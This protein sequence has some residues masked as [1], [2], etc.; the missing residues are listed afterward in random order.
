MCA[1]VRACV[2]ACVC[3]ACVCEGSTQGKYVNSV[4]RRMLRERTTYRK[5]LTGSG[6]LKIR[7]FNKLVVSNR[8]FGTRG[9][10]RGYSP[11]SGCLVL[12]KN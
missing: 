10:A 9:T 3:V 8:I 11:L 4:Q 6:M 1:C 7:Q 12:T 5:Q 2:R